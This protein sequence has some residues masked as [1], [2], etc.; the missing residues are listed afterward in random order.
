MRWRFHA[1]RIRQ[2]E[3]HDSRHRLQMVDI[4]LAPRLVGDTVLATDVAMPGMSGPELSERLTRRWPGLH[5]LFLSGYTEERLGERHLV[6]N[7]DYLSKPFV[8]HGLL[9]RVRTS[10]DARPGRS[11][12][13]GRT[14]A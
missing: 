2:P 12:G 1:L 7:A 8:S 11:A 10:L 13:I 6:A 5:T 14:V 4:R 3:R 9:E